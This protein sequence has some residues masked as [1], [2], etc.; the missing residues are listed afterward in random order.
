LGFDIFNSSR[1][2][3]FEV[4]VKYEEIQKA[5]LFKKDINE[6]GWYVEP[7][8]SGKVILRPNPKKYP[9]YAPDTCF[10]FGTIE[11]IL[12]Y[13]EGPYDGRNY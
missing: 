2:V 1:F 11:E 13:I 6:K 12:V 4:S 10:R 7:D 3:F 5:L 8:P 9:K